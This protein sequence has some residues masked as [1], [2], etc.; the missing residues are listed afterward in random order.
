[1]QGSSIY[2]T[3]YC[4][5]NQKF[6]FNYPADWSIS[7]SGE[8]ETFSV[9]V[10]NPSNSLSAT[11]I[12]NDTRDGHVVPFYVKDIEDLAAPDARLKTISGFASRSENSKP[13]FI[14]IGAKLLIDYPVVI[15]SESNFINTARFDQLNGEPASLSVSPIGKTFTTTEAKEWFTSQD[16]ATARLIIR[17]V[18]FSEN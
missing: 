13:Y 2:W 15:G 6:C 3:K 17:S 12:R 4:D 1:M 8:E 16:A 18:S 7:Q 9:R 10:V 14:L 5:D 11:Y